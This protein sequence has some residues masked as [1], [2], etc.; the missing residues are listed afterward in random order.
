MKRFD[1]LEFD[2]AQ[3]VEL[4]QS[5]QQQQRERAPDHDQHYWMRSATDHR[6]RGL[7]EEALKLYSRALELD[8]S[9]VEG[10]TAQVRML[11]AMGEYPE[12]ELW[13]RKALELF[14][15][16]PDLLA[17]RC[18]ALCRT[19][20]LKTAAA[21]SDSAV[22]QQGAGSYPWMARGELMLARKERL[23][24]YCFDKAVQLDDDW[25]VPLEIGDIFLHYR[26][27]AK[28]LSRIKQ[29]V[30]K[31]PD[32]AYCWYRQ[33]A[34]ELELGLSGPASKS[35]SRCLQLEP[36]HADARKALAEMAGGR[37]SIRRFFRRLFWFIE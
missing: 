13:S 3:P 14:K 36:K 29:A 4:G 8:R 26:R 1:R 20:D 33:G 32:S 11:I 9:L 31:A 19:G 22:S 2:H 35:L 21:I 16:N 27:A 6:R 24:D 17:G 15:N 34:C 37:G 5:H 10:W 28:A 12:A 18:Q 30:E 25:L 23:D 7:F